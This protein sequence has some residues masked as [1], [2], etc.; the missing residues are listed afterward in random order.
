M[1]GRSQSA[2]SGGVLSSIRLEQ[3]WSCMPM[4]YI[5]M[6]HAWNLFWLYHSCLPLA[7]VQLAI[8]IA[9]K[10]FKPTAHLIR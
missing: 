1:I 4:N 8:Y 2:L 9:K 7:V 3:R 6:R 10:I 5:G